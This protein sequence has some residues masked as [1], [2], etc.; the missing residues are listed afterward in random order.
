MKVKYQSNNPEWSAD[1]T[2]EQCEAII[3]LES[4]D[5][6]YFISTLKK[7]YTAQWYEPVYYFDCPVCNHKNQI[8]DAIRKDISS[9]IPKK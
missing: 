2:C 4:A 8:R 1:V 7:A 9:K 6:M 5:D 3:T